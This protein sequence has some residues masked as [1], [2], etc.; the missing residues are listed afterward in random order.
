M[1]F[2]ARAIVADVHNGALR[3]GVTDFSSALIIAAEPRTTVQIDVG[4][5]PA[6]AID[7]LTA[8]LKVIELYGLPEPLCSIERR[9]AKRFESMLKHLAAVRRGYDYLCPEEQE[10]LDRYRAS[11]TQDKA[12]ASDPFSTEGFRLRLWTVKG[13]A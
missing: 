8:V 5:C 12:K 2:H 13:D 9:H 11:A 7:A 3:M 6:E 10:I 1:K 4:I